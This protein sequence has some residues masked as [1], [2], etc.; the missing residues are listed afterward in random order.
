VNKE[1][2]WTDTLPAC[3]PRRILMILSML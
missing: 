2:K 3:T 1:Q